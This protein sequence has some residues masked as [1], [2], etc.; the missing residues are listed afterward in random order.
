MR[1][2]HV[3]STLYRTRIK[4]QKG[5]TPILNLSLLF[6]MAALFTAPWLVIAG[7]AVALVMG[8]HLSVERDAP[9][10][11]GNF[12]EVVN[13]AASNVKSAVDSFTEKKEQE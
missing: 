8:Y 11:S 6:S 9:Q 1:G 10:F 4:A 13:D 12:Q 5:D 3:F 2:N 7:L